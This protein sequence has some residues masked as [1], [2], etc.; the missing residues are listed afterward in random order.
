MYDLT[1]FTLQNMT[2]CGDD[3]QQFG[4]KARNIEELANLMVHYFYDHFIDKKTGEK[5]CALVRFF[6]TYPY[7]SIDEELRQL[8]DKILD[9]QPVPQETKCLV[10]LASAGLQPEWNSTRLSKGHRVL[11]LLNEDMLKQNPM[12]YQ[13]IYQL[14]IDVSSVLNPDPTLALELERKIFNVY[15]VP[16]APGSP[17]IPAQNDFVI[18]FGIKSVL[19]F[20]SMLPTGNLFALVIFSRVKIP[21]NT[22]DMF[23]N[24]E[25]NVRMAVM[26]FV[27]EK[28]FVIDKNEITET[29]RLRSLMATQ[30]NLLEMY[31]QTAIDQSRR[32]ESLSLNVVKFL[33]KLTRKSWLYIS[34]V[35]ASGI[36]LFVHQQTHIEFALHLAAIPLEILLGVLVIEKLL[37]RK[38]KAERLKKLTHVKSYL[39]RSKMRNLFLTNLNA[40]RFPA[41]TVSK[42]KNATLE[43]LKQMRNDADHIEYASLEAM[44]AV[45][46][47]Y[48]SAYHVFHEF[49]EKAI[50]DD[51][52]SNFENMLYILHFIEDVKLFKQKHPDKLFIYEAQNQ[53]SLMKKVKKIMGDGILKFLDYMIELKEKNPDMFYDLLTDYELS[54]L[55]HNTLN[56][57]N[58]TMRTRE[59]TS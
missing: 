34:L 54:S 18:P 40:L 5:S 29:E 11:P 43:E 2:R 3:L 23:K 16:D 35:S 13:F 20:G 4:S 1:K 30:I 41:I 46:M 42:I 28:I 36:F 59:N 58:I 8:A 47:E 24:I 10:L 32:L 21:R 39:F 25:L 48:V 31:K 22:A 49:M 51:I 33:G 15:Y 53:R 17:Y 27:S 9:G 56:L 19:G 14:G 45:I 52:D 12:V 55:G 7:T 44:E 26:P 38:N 37:E 6:M 50:P 57:K